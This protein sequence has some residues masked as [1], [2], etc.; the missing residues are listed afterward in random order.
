[1][2]IFLQPVSLPKRCFLQEVL[3]WVAFKRLPVA[4]FTLDGKEIRETEEIGDYATSFLDGS[5]DDEETQAAKIPPDPSWLASLEERSTLPSVKYEE[6]LRESNLAPDF[7]A[8][9]EQE[10]EKALEFER[11]LDAWTPL[12]QGVLEYPSSRIFVALKEGRLRARGRKLPSKDVDEALS[13]LAENGYSTFDLAFSDI[14]S[15]FW[16]L[17]GINFDASTAKSET[18]HYCHINFDTEEVLAVFPGERRLAGTVEQ[19]GV[20]FVLSGNAKTAQ[21]RTK[22]GRPSYPWEPFYIEVADLIRRGELPKKKEAA[23]EYFKEWFAKNFAIR[24]SRAAI[25][26]KLT[27]YYDKFVR[28]DGQKI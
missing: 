1:M 2:P 3:Y 5:V 18:D 26:E 10:R 14:P 23:I 7:R 4:Q 28:S 21:L 6:Q 19:V 8:W 13:G 24:P 22:R 11:E 9:L 12:Y 27:P 25:G 15:S 17:Q 16:T 20:S